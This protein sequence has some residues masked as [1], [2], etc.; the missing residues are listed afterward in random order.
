[1]NIFEEKNALKELVDTFSILADQKDTQKQATLF[2]EDATLKSYIG[3]QLTSEQHGRKEICEAC[4][5]FLS[6]FD[7]VYH[8]NGQQVVNVEGDHA[9][10]TAYCQVV[11][12]GN[13]EEGKR[14]MN[15][16][17][18]WYEDEYIKVDGKW[19]IAKRVSHFSWADSKEV[20]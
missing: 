6:L 17:G 4:T 14:M 3:G 7:T 15:T 18:V 10:G 8:I 5:G 19:L 11:L 12:I 2:T 20:R 13:N 9:T 16:N 1:M